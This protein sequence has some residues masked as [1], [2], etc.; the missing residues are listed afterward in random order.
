MKDLLSKLRRMDWILSACM[1]SLIVM[2]VVFINSAGSVRPT[3]AL[4]NLWRVHATTALF[5]LVVYV[6]FAFLDY[7]K[8]LDWAALPAFAVSCTLLV[9]VLFAG[10]DRF[11]G[12]RWLWFFQPSEIAKLAV[13]LFTAHVFAAPGRTDFRGFLAGAGILC[14]PAALVL[15]EPDLGT[16]LVLVPS[17]LVILLAARVWLKGL[18][19]LLAAGLLAAG[20]VLWAVDRAEREPDPDRRARIYRFVPLRDHQIKRLRVFLFPETDRS[21]AGYNL[22]QAQIAV[23]SGGIWGKGLKKGSQK[24][25]GYLPPSVSMNDFIFAVLAEESGFMGVLLML[26]LFLGILGPG[27]RIA[28]RCRDDRGRLVVIG[29]LTLVFCHLYV[30]VAMSVGLVP[31]TGLPLPFISAGRT[32]LI[33]LMAALGVVQSVAIHSPEPVGEDRESEGAAN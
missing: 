29:I 5:G 27:L 26:A 12:R 13:I 32:F 16:A 9:I 17:V 3:D 6:A 20:L 18:V 2:G 31:I 15:A 21:G 25:L 8:L 10:T 30:N 1:V 14:G 22:R 7:R 4:R 19:T 11:G 24:L 33:V 28:A 23:G